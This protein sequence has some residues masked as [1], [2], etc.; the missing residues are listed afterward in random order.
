MSAESTRGEPR[1]RACFENGPETA[2]GCMTVC[3]LPLDH[4]GPHEWT[5]GDEV[6]IRFAPRDP[7]LDDALARAVYEPMPANLSDS[8]RSRLRT[9]RERLEALRGRIG[10]CNI[11]CP[12]ELAPV[13]PW[14]EQW[15]RE[16]TEILKEEGP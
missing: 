14:T 1:K 6:T 9:Q 13:L 16:L 15:E 12:P 3:V 8:L 7:T 2:D 10:A 5:R 11:S 4:A